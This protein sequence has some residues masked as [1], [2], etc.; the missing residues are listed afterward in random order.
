MENINKTKLKEILKDAEKE[1]LELKHPYVGSEHLFLSIIKG[2]NNLS[3]YLKK[4]NLDYQ[5]FKNELLSIVGSC[6]KK[7]DSNLYTPLLRKIIKRYESKDDELIYSDIN[8]DLFLCLLDE[9][10]GI[11]IRIMLRMNIDLDEIYFTLKEKKKLESMETSNKVGTLLNNC[12][13]INE[14]VI[15]RESELNKIIVTLTRKKKCNPLLIGP[16]GVGK[17]AIVEELTRRIIRNEVPNLLKGYKIVMVEMGSLISGTKYRGEFEERLN[18]IIKEIKNNK[19]TIIFID[20]IHSMVNAGGAEGAINASDILKPYLARGD[21]KC[22]GATTTGEY[23]NYILKDKALMRRFD[24]INVD[25][26]NKEEMKTILTKIKKEYENYHEIK[27]PNKLINKVIDLSD[28]YLRNIVNPDK[29]IDLLDS[30]CAY[31]KI[32]GNKK[33][34]TE[35]DLL[36]TIYYKTSNSLIYNNLFKGK[37]KSSLKKLLDQ[38]TVIKICDSFNYVD[39]KPISIILDNENILNIIKECLSNINIVNIDLGSYS[40][41]NSNS[42]IYDKLATDNVFSSLIDKPYSLIIFE[43]VDQGN[44]Y[45]L[46]EISK[47][48]KEGY[49]NFKYN[50][51]IYFNNAI[52]IATY[53]SDNGKQTGFSNNILKTKLSDSFINSFSCD[54]RDVIKKEISLG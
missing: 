7:N 16:A 38:R 5:N 33:E 41:Y 35:K 50:E 23:N 8:E 36:N 6:T 27:I 12:V 44:K 46:D 18:K 42:L 29:S 20:E 21:I 30:A 13:D 24:V 40:L 48:N 28:Y 45:I 10:E 31:A 47:I 54:I 19:K 9:G 26:P 1:R 3:E 11:A 25:E 43:N 53:K 2:K 15:G 32:N 14:K 22:I 51:K 49:I 17:T 52:I 34:L 37:L 4:Y 39:N